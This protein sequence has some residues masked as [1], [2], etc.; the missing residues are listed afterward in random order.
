M[1]RIKAKDYEDLSDT[2]I[3]KVIAALNASPA[4]SKKE[5]CELLKISYNTTRL[6]NI[7]EEF[8][9]RQENIKRLKDKKRGRPATNDEI[10]YI[11]SEYMNGAPIYSISDRLYRSTNFIKAIVEQVGIPQ[12]EPGF[13]P[14]KPQLLPESCIAEDFE[15]GEIAWCAQ[16][17]AK[18]KIEKRLDDN[19]YIPKY[20]APCYSVYILG[21]GFFSSSLAYDLGKL[22]HLEGYG[23]NLNDI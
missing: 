22:S 16:Y 23:I 20:G 14:L 17:R 11:I 1:A 6:A 2:N 18:C 13:S 9:E 15:K 5:A 7:I 8:T 12:R 3:R 19:Y 21:E 10:N 4:I